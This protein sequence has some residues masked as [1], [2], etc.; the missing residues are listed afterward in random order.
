VPSCYADSVAPNDP[1]T[2]LDA[3]PEIPRSELRARVDVRDPDLIVVDVLA[4]DSYAAA[5]IPTARNLPYA[6]MTEPS[7]RA[8]LPDRHADI[9]LYCGGF[10]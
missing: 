2:A 7:V 5:H 10:T 1:L 3:V 4:A 8:A 6:S 9:V